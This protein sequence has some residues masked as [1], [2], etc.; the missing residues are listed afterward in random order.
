M[1]N[2][3]VALILLLFSPVTGLAAVPDLSWYVESLC[4]DDGLACTSEEV[5]YGQC[6]HV[7]NGRC[8]QQAVG[9]SGRRAGRTPAL[10]TGPHALRFDGVDDIVTVRASRALP[11]TTAF[12]LEAWVRPAP[13]PR[14]LSCGVIAGKDGEFLLGRT[15]R[16]TLEWA[17]NAAEP[18]FVFVE[19]AGAVVPD[20]VWSHVALTYDGARVHAFLNGMLVA[21]QTAAGAIRR[22]AAPVSLFRIGGR[23]DRGAGSG[24][25]AGVIDDVRLWN[26]A[27]GGAAIAADRSRRLRGDEAGLIG[28]WRLDEGRGRAAADTARGHS[29]VLANGPVW[30]DG[31]VKPA[32]AWL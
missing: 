23:Y 14:S 4:P 22:A 17:L 13:A 31:R 28:Y 3:R 8:L 11:V 1:P 30:V 20:G 19:A 9:D 27:R 10:P 24:H 5:V 12:T 18:G 16:G 2:R 15:R 25:F 29:G 7:P 21:T 6:L 32:S 26:V